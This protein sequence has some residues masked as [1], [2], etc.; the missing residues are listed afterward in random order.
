[1]VVVRT[2][3]IVVLLITLVV[4]STMRT[5]IV[6][7]QSACSNPGT[8]NSANGSQYEYNTAVNDY[9]NCL[10]ITA[11]TSTPTATPTTT[12]TP[13][14]TPTATPTPTLLPTPMT[15]ATQTGCNPYGEANAYQ[16]CVTEDSHTRADVRADVWA[17]VLVFSIVIIA[18]LRWK[19]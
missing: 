2:G 11:N 15:V 4:V 9:Q 6:V 12:S 17:P 18:I 14:A 1:M 10:V 16:T 5:E 19:S 8:F 13:T 3:L 7:A